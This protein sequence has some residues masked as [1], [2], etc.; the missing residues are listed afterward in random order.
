MKRPFPTTNSTM[1]MPLINERLTSITNSNL[2]PE[3]ED[4][5]DV[6]AMERQ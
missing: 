1:K 6:I 3:D 5:I 2:F 4:W